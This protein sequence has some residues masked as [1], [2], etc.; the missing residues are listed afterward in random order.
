MFFNFRRKSPLSALIPQVMGYIDMHCHV[1]PG[2]DDGAKD[3]KER[4]WHF[5]RHESLGL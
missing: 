4:T 5:K 2:I 1:L 3:I